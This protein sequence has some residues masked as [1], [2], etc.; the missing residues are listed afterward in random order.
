MELITGRPEPRQRRDLDYLVATHGD[1]TATDGTRQAILQ[2]S[3]VLAA[4]GHW[5]GRPFQWFELESAPDEG[6][7][8]TFALANERVVTLNGRAI[9]AREELLLHRVV[10]REKQWV[11]V[12]MHPRIARGVGPVEN[13][14]FELVSPRPATEFQ[15][16][17][18]EVQRKMIDAMLDRLL[19]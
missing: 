7:P 13:T 3:E 10:R 15:E 6:E 19:V 14:E 11:T 16:A 5:V 12:S 9:R 18:M 1:E 8:R 4:I 2:L 17:V